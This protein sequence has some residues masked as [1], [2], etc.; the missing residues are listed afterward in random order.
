MSTTPVGYNPS[1]TPISGTTQ[2]GDLAVGTSQQDYSSKPGGIT[3]WMGPEQELGYVVAKPV[4]S[5][6]QPFNNSISATAAYVG[7]SRST[8]L[9]QSSFVNL[10]NSIAAGA[11]SFTNS[12]GTQAKTWLNDNGYWTSYGLSPSL[13]LI[14]DLDSSLGVSGSSWYDQSGNENNATLYGGYGTTAYISGQVVTLNGINGYAFPA[15]GFGTN[16]NSGFTYDVWAYPSKTGNGTLLA[17]WSGTPPTGWNDTQMAF[18]SGTI[19]AG[20]YPNTFTPTGYLTGPSFSVNT[21]YN[22]V[23][24]Y[25]DSG[26]SLKL[27]VNGNLIGT[28]VGT[29]LNPSP[30]TYLTLGRPDTAN[31]YIGGATGYFEGYIGSWKIW[32]GPLSASSVLSN[33]NSYKSRY[34]ALVTSGLIIYLDANNTSSYPGTG[35]SIFNLQSGSYTHTKVNAPYTVL[36]GVKC[37]DCNGA[38]TV[39]EVPQSTGPTLPVSGYTY[40]SWARVRTSSATWRTLFRTYPNDHPILVQISTDNLGFYDNDTAAFR[41]SGYDVTSI[42]DIWVQYSVVGDSSS[43]IFYING[44]QVGTTAYGA[45][46]NT[47]WAWGAIAGQPFGYV[48]NMLYYNRKLSLSEIAQNYN[49]FLSRF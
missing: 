34:L 35:D 40:I 4:P 37:F 33:Y 24:T 47:H 13:S 31:S 41:D 16:L 27:Y 26:G 42:E 15:G 21:W 17:E 39:I 44:V 38:S 19:N 5:G 43:S 36:N 23:M 7:F 25:D 14:M 29:K 18:V 12:Q 49:F 6:T 3:Y 30:G 10:T 46:G 11:T 9:T 22:I 48:A 32:D 20:V 2:V 45:G 8:A 28:T 1:R